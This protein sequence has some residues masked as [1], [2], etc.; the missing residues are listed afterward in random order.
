[1]IT[2][3]FFNSAFFESQSLG[4]SIVRLRNLVSGR[5]LAINEKGRVV[6]QV[7]ILCKTLWL[8]AMVCVT[9]VTIR[10][11]RCETSFTCNFN[12][13]TLLSD[14]IVAWNNFCNGW[15]RFS[16]QLKIAVVGLLTIYQLKSS[17]LLKWFSVV[18]WHQ[19]RSFLV[20]KLLF[21]FLLN[22]KILELFLMWFE[23]SLSIHV[24]DLCL[25]NQILYRTIQFQY[26]W[27]AF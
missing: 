26:C 19:T 5:F 2:P 22:F 3:L 25:A 16:A 1:M 18:K 15:Y 27:T 10:R 13:D 24:A 6:T 14:K 12:M 9:C 20:G 21:L 4:T 7:R 17:L 11:E 23:S 8:D